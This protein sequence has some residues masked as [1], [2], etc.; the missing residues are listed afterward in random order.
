MTAFISKVKEYNPANIFTPT[1]QDTVVFFTHNSPFSNHHL[2]SFTVENIRYNCAEQYIM[3]QKAKLFKDEDSLKLI[4]Q[5]TDPKKQKTLG[6]KIEGFKQQDWRK[7]KLY[8]TEGLR[9]KC[10]KTHILKNS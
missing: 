6:K 7:Q 10:Y 2:A 9:Q 1:S 5:E 3:S 4:M 8:V